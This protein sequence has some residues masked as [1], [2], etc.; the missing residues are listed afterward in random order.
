MRRADIAATDQLELSS[1]CAHADRTFVTEL[2]R[3]L[4][5]SIPFCK[6]NL[7]VRSTA[8]LAHVQMK[9]MRESVA[10]FLF[11]AVLGSK[12][13]AEWDVLECRAVDMDYFSKC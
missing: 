8:T 10:S 3:R 12:V 1:S 11:D 13:P 7:F 4:G 9:W 6:E 5:C 2:C